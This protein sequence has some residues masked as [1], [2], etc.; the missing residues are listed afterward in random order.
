VTSL[1]LR[2]RQVAGGLL[3]LRSAG[4]DLGAQ[5]LH[6]CVTG[7]ERLLGSCKTLSELG[8]D[9]FEPLPFRPGLH[10]AALAREERAHVS[11]F[12]RIA[13]GEPL[14]GLGRVRPH[15]QHPKPCPWR[16]VKCVPGAHPPSTAGPKSASRTL[17]SRKRTPPKR[18]SF[19]SQVSK[20]HCLSVQPTREQVDGAVRSAMRLV[21]GRTNEPKK[22]LYR[23]SYSSEDAKI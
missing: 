20:S 17:M 6:P 14:C 2:L 22:L 8:W 10:D 4:G 3:E 1:R 5:L 12:L 15:Y 13:R 11:R 18:L 7:G 21:E 16:K 19:G 9:R 23:G